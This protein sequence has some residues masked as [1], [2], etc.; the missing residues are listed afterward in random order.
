MNSRHCFL[1][2]VASTPSTSSSSVSSSSNAA[3]T[4]STTVAS[5]SGPGRGNDSDSGAILGASWPLLASQA[6]GQREPKNPNAAPTQPMTTQ[7][8]KYCADYNAV[9]GHAGAVAT[10]SAASPGTLV[11][12][13][14]ET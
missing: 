10:P 7:P 2:S 5:S 11:V 9:A 12:I 8:K 1:V 4:A 14:R 3:G 13:V 6:G